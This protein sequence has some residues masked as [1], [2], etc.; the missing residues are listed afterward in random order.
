[1]PMINYNKNGFRRACLP[2]PKDLDLPLYV[3]TFGVTEREIVIDREKASKCYLVYSHRGC[4]RHG[5]EQS[6]N[7]VDSDETEGEDGD[8]PKNIPRT[9]EDLALPHLVRQRTN[10][11]RRHRCGNGGGGYHGGDLRCG[12]LEHLIDEYV[13]IHVFH[14]PRDLPRKA[15]DGEGEEKFCF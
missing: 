14:D 4:G 5:R 10:K 11:N 9:D 6:L 13:E 2:R 7:D 8:P 3:L 12:C 1:M 15:E